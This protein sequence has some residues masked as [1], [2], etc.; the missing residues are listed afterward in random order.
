MLAAAALVAL[1]A[2]VVGALVAAKSGGGRDAPLVPRAVASGADPL[3]FR[4]DAVAELESAAAAGYSHV[5]YAKS[6][7]GIVASARRTAAFRPLIDAAART[8]HIDADLLEAIVLLESAGRPDVIAGADPA[9]A[10][11]LTQ[12][13]AET[14]QNFLRM[15]VDLA[16]SRKLTAGIVAANARGDARAAERFRAQRR[17][18]DERFDPAR[19]LA[20]TVRYLETARERFGRD[21]LALVSY[22]MGIGNLTSVIRD[23]SGERSAPIR[24]VVERD[25]LSYAQLYF[26]STPRRHAA[27]WRRLARLG[28]DSETYYWRLLA[29]REVMHLYRTDRSR[30]EELARLQLN[31]ASAEEVLHPADAT[32]RFAGPAD[33]A[34][35][36][37][38]GV[39]QPLPTDPASLHFRIDPHMG[40]LA[41]GLGEKSVL[42]RGLRKEALALLVYLAGR[43]HALSGAEQPL[44]VTSTVRDERYQALLRRTNPEATQKYSLHTTGYA[45]DIL[46]RYGSD[47]Q[48]AAFQYELERLQ[49]RDLIAWVREPAAIHVTVSSDA[50][51]LVPALLQQAP[52][53]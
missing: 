37:D 25:G 8:G 4:A 42:Y 1:A 38:R 41:P 3:A 31:K 40:E 15:R 35:A 51:V 11:G 33:V 43:V 2:G 12:I 39:L 17:V 52:T 36:R 21:D 44:V 14:A 5:L 46:R 49:A 18:V 34:Q 23:Y 13:V 19:A 48:A 47:A 53:P 7:G 29:A 6:P 27:A 28:D 22:H 32:E 45:F 26:D 50:A 24:D 30:L 20:G 16:T 10:A 9:R